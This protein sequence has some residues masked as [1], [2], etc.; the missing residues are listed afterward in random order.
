MKWCKKGDHEVD[1]SEFGPSKKAKDGLLGSCRICINTYYRRRSKMYACRKKRGA[2]V[3][4]RFQI[5]SFHAFNQAA[6]L[7]G[8][9]RHDA[10][11][12]AIAASCDEAFAELPAGSVE[13][14]LK[15]KEEEDAKR[16]DKSK[17][18]QPVP[19]L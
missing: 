6:L 17:E 8:K 5:A 10:F 9:E 18:R 13:T 4:D 11:E 2:S 7:G 19:N 16:M 12:S 3:R 1:E 14:W 15:F